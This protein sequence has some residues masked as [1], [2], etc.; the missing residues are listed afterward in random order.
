MVKAR[1]I[2]APKLCYG[3]GSMVQ[4]QNGQWEIGKDRGVI[5]YEFFKPSDQPIGQ[6][7]AVVNFKARNRNERSITENQVMDLIKRLIEDAKVRGMRQLS[8]PKNT[9]NFDYRGKGTL[10]EDLF[11]K[12]DKKVRFIV[13][14]IPKDDDIYNEIKSVA[15]L[16]KF[17][18]GLATQCMCKVG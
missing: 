17:G 13:F 14:L 18:R 8:C 7:W 3:K 2:D 5:K 1:I 16:N 15:E 12:L 10:E 11:D 4:L 9:L 6:N